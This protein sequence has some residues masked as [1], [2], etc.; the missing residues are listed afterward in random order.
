VITPACVAIFQSDFKDRTLWRQNWIYVALTT[1]VAIGAFSQNSIPLIFLIYPLLVIL[2]LRADLGWAALTLLLV[3]I[4][5]SWYTLRGQG[6]FVATAPISSL[7]PILL[8]QM[9]VAVGMFMLYSVSVVMERQKATERK[10]REIVSLHTLMTE[11]SRDLIILAD[12]NGHRSFVSAAAESL[13]GWK[14]E[15][16]MEQD[17][18][19]LVHP[20]DLARAQA[21]LRDLRSG[22]EGAMLELR[23]RKRSGEYFWAE[24]ILR[25][26]RDPVTGLPCGILNTVRDISERKRAEEARE[27]HN[28]LIRAIHEVSLDGILVVND[29][30]NV[31]SHNKKFSDIW[32]IPMADFVVDQ[33]EKTSHVPARR[34]LS[35]VSCLVKDSENFERRVREINADPDANDQCHVEL[36]D[37]RTLERYSTSL[38]G[39]GGKYLGRVWFFTDITERKQDEQRLQ[40]A[41][42][43]VEALALTDGLTGLANRRRFDQYLA[44]EWRRSMRDRQPLSL[45]ML[46]ADK[47]KSYNDTYGHLRGDSCLRQIAEA[48]QDV[49]SRP[50]DLVARFGGEEFTVVLPNTESEGA[51]QVAQEIC[52]ALRGRQLPHSGNPTGI[53]TISIGCATLVPQF[54]RHAPELIARADKVLYEAKD[55]GRDQVCVANTVEKRGEDT[56]PGSAV[57]QTV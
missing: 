48:C 7:R 28:S 47:F 4:V 39:E 53:V 41:Y 2:A 46:D 18:L 14:P 22:A 21:A 40:E 38:R 23:L 25:V 45:L 9:Y 49:V 31:V 50:G 35:K 17:G 16:L 20:E 6:L 10:L 57:G 13:G 37:G 27:F 55:K 36:R 32:Q 56:P 54:G 5:G 11:S 24:S 19:F 51:L 29:Q 43:A 44:A 1:V 12:F 52:E 42:R 15:E 3:V 30:G 34:I 8:L 26:T 33:D